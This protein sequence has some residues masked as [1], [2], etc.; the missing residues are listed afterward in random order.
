MDAVVRVEVGDDDLAGIEAQAVELP[1]EPPPAIGHRAALA[2]HVARLERIEDVEEVE[3]AAAEDLSQ[4]GHV[5]TTGRVRLAGDDRD[6]P[7]AGRPVGLGQGPDGLEQLLVRLGVGRDQGHVPEAIRVRHRVAPPGEEPEEVLALGAQAAQL[8]PSTFG[9]FVLSGSGELLDPPGDRR[10]AAF[11]EGDAPGHVA[12]GEGPGPPV[13]IH[14]PPDLDRC[15][16]HAAGQH[17]RL[18]EP[19]DVEGQDEPGHDL[20]PAERERNRSDDEHPGDRPGNDLEDSL[21]PAIARQ[22]DRFDRGACPRGV[23]GSPAR[24]DRDG[25]SGLSHRWGSASPS[26]RAPASAPERRRSRRPGSAG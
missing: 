26:V 3:E 9:G 13:D 2:D 22:G 7:P 4:A 19:V 5:L 6:H 15:H 20:G 21:D 14:G 18:V 12:K 17:R 25:S 16:G 8:A 23:A 11:D 10:R 24:L 1:K